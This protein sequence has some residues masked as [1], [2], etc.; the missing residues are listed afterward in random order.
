MQKTEVKGLLSQLRSA[1]EAIKGQIHE[2][3]SQITVLNE[4]RSA[5]TDAPVS[6]SD[7]MAYV[8][9]DSHRHAQMYQHKIEKKW[10]KDYKFPFSFAL[11]ERNHTNGEPQP[12]SYLD[13]ESPYGELTIAAHHWYLNELIAKRFLDAMVNL[14]WPSNAV[15]VADRRRMITEIDTKLQELNGKRDELAND[16]ISSGMYE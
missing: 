15:P 3:D 4:Q 16:L 2:I 10:A 11:L 8:A 6:K 5:L 13:G 14:P 9:M 12:F 7:F 1:A